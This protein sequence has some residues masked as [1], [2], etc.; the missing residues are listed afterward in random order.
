MQN[1]KKVIK[2]K[3]KIP[4][5]RIKKL[6]G[7]IIIIAAIVLL[8]SP[9]FVNR[10]TRSEA[11][12]IRVSLAASSASSDEPTGISGN[13]HLK[14]ELQEIANGFKEDKERDPKLQAVI[15]YNESLR[16]GQQKDKLEF[17][18]KCDV[19]DETEVFGT[20]QIPSISVDMPLYIGSSDEN[21]AAGAAVLEG[22]SLP[23]GGESTNSVISGHR[24]W[25]GAAYFKEIESVAWGDEII[26]TNPWETLIY[27]VMDVAVIEPTGMEPLL[28]REGQD[29]ITLVTCHPYRSPRNMR[30]VVYAVREEEPV[31]SSASSTILNNSRE[32]KEGADRYMKEKAVL[33]SSYGSSSKEI[34]MEEG[35]RRGSAVCCILILLVPLGRYLYRACGKK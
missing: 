9:E 28:I 18:V 29:M 32:S 16:H 13:T 24:G 31:E 27:Y 1:I 7:I 22:T 5:E 26:I 20:I 6:V 23:I 17:S 15:K 4:V 30:Y 10:N 11:Q 3:T 33:L 2:G 34:Q 14:N 35:I 8:I 12:R 21:L 19:W 25:K